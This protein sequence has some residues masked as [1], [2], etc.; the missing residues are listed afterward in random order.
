MSPA[1]RMTTPEISLL[2]FNCPFGNL[3]KT[4]PVK[5]SRPS[6]PLRISSAATKKAP[7]LAPGVF[8]P[9]LKVSFPWL[10]LRVSFNSAP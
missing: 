5:I 9:P 8:P 3:V 10:P 4:P 7:P 1:L 2:S 6:S